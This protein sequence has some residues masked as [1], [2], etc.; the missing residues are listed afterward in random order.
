VPALD[1]L[2]VLARERFRRHAPWFGAFAE[3][4]SVSEIAGEHHL[5]VTN[6]RN[7]LREIDSFASSSPRNLEGLR[8]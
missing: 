5:F 7:V 1:A 8:A 6:A 2:Y 4:G 3:R